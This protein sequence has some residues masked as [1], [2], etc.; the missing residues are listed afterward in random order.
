MA[1][2]DR[3]PV[4]A[5]ILTYNEEQNLER[6]LESLSGWVGEI[7]VVD[8]FSTDRTIEIAKRYTDRIFHHAYANH[9]QQ[10]RWTFEHVPFAYEWVLAVDADF[11]VTPELWAAIAGALGRGDPGIHG[12]F[13]RHR[14]VFRGRFLRHGTIYPRYWLRLFRRGSVRID[15]LDLVDVHFYVDGPTGRSSTISSKTTERTRT[16]SSG[17]RS[18]RDS[19][20]ARPPKRC[21]DRHPIAPG[22]R[23]RVFSGRRTSVRSGSRSAGTACRCTCGPFCCSCIGTCS[24][25]ASSTGGRGSSTT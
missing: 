2:A 18:R 8:S 11:S 17:S 22:R 20:S 7:V 3:V 13:V 21:G 6:C 23:E 14:Q 1:D 10:W 16:S 19:P 24:G 15:P 4:S 9:P 5:V 12:Y 25:L